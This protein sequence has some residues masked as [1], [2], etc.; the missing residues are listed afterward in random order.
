MIGS[1]GVTSAGV[2]IH[3]V[4]GGQLDKDSKQAVNG[5]QL[6]EVK[7]DLA[8]TEDQR[9]TMAINLNGNNVKIGNLEEQAQK[10]KGQLTQLEKR[11]GEAD[12]KFEEVRRG[13]ETVSNTFAAN[14][15][16]IK[17]GFTR[18][19]EAI[20]ENEEKTQQGFAR[21]G[22]VIQAN[23]EKNEQGFAAVG[24]RLEATDK[25]VEVVTKAFDGLNKAQQEAQK[26]NGEKFVALDKRVGAANVELG[27]ISASLNKQ[28]ENATGRIGALANQVQHHDTQLKSLDKK[29]SQVDRKAQQGIAAALAVAAIP[30][31]VLPNENVI[32]F[33]AGN[34]R[35]A[36]GMAIG[37]SHASGNG[38]WLFKVGAVNAGNNYGANAGIGYRW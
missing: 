18:V 17:E 16:A 7:K 13:F 5:A 23:E 3:N 36:N 26:E 31:A 38:K 8:E 15:K 33:A 29:V 14:D 19:G 11:A 34:W 12:S 22:E 21:V 32:A 4:A 1:K 6:F 20:R 9:K 10:H 24:K 30:Q 37:F 25:K 2:T 35:S 27:K 28:L